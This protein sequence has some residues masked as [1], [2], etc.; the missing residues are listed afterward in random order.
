MRNPI[1]PELIE[2]AENAVLKYGLGYPDCNI[3]YYMSDMQNIFLAFDA[4][5][6]WYGID[7]QPGW[8]NLIIN[9][10]KSLDA[11]CPEYSIVQIKEKFGTLRFYYVLPEN[12]PSY[13]KWGAR[14]L[15]SYA[16]L[17]SAKTCESCG[18][19]SLSDQVKSHQT[20]GWVHTHCAACELAYLEKNRDKETPNKTID[21]LLTQL[22]ET[23]E[24]IAEKK[25]K[26]KL[27]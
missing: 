21:A 9:L 25:K 7:C 5:P 26:M 2:K 3:N 15:A 12:T 6:V 19:D 18:T 17:L 8:L 14:T 10:H 4:G 13:I 24:Q 11:L 22:K 20:F 23:V 27:L 1:T 16:E